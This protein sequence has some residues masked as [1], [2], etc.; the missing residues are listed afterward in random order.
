MSSAH[1]SVIQRSRAG[2]DPDDSAAPAQ[3]A[4]STRSS[5][6]SPKIIVLCINHEV[7]HT[8]YIYYI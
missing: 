3:F 4:D 1:V 7:L 5:K 8:S 2:G 6:S